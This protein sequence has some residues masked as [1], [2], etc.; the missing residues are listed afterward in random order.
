MSI[1]SRNVIFDDF[2]IVFFQQSF[3]KKLLVDKSVP[4]LRLDLFLSAREMA[5]QSL[6]RCLGAGPLRGEAV[7]YVE[8]PKNVSIAGDL[9]PFRYF[10]LK[11]DTV[12]RP[13]R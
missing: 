4:S 7:S 13:G 3:T 6:L 11:L 9:F 10:I 1:L 8:P 2:Y 5:R 12:H